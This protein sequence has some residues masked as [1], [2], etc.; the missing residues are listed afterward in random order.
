MNWNLRNRILI[1]TLSLFLLGVAG[2]AAYSSLASEDALDN[3]IRGQLKLVCEALNR[4]VESW[5][6]QVRREVEMTGHRENVVAILRFPGDETVRARSNRLL[7]EAARLY[8]FEAFGIADTKGRIVASTDFMD[9]TAYHVGERGYFVQS[10]RG[11]NSIS[12]IIHSKVSQNLIVVFAS[13]V[14]ISGEIV[15]VIFATVNL[16]N[17]S[18]RFVTPIQVGE[19]GYAVLA[20]ANGRILAHPDKSLILADFSSSEFGRA[21]MQQK[22]GEYSYRFRERFVHSHLQTAASTGWF[23]VVRADHEDIFSPLKKLRAATARI[24]IGMAALIGVILWFIVAG[25]TRPIRQASEFADAVSRGDLTGDLSLN[26]KDEIGRLAASMLAMR[27]CIQDAVSELTVL[28]GKIREGRLEHRGDAGRFEGGW[29]GVIDG[30]NG[31][32]D[33]FAGPFAVVSDYVE[34]IAAGELPRRISKVYAGDF[35]RI[36]K[37]LN[38]LIDSSDTVTQL[39][40][41]LAAGDLTV[42]VVERSSNDRLMQALNK[43][44]Q[45]LAE[46]TSSVRKAADQVALGSRHMQAASESMAEGASRQAASSEEASASMEEMASSTSQNAD[47]AA[48]TERIAVKAVEDAGRSLEAANKSVRAMKEIAREIVVVEDI[49][50][51]TNLL[52]LN[53]AIEAARAGA[54][55]KGF[56]V[57]AMEI[58]KLSEKSRQS[59]ERISDLSSSTMEIAEA[60]GG[61]LGDLMPDIGRTADLVQ[62][63]S[64]ASGQQ[65]AGAQ[66]LNRAIQDL[67][68]VIQ[69]N[70]SAAEEMSSTA[71]EL[72]AQAIHLQEAVSFFRTP[73]GKQTPALYGAAPGSPDE[74]SGFENYR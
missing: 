20:D 26:R 11:K 55:G 34:K 63:I 29:K 46:I 71:A 23:V 42:N 30:V 57:V 68:I 62:E 66:Q 47:N 65:S 5:A 36:R 21:M 50:G 18:T 69:R 41:R 31:V 60:A 24:T 56:A 52:A 2:V 12:R 74:S 61:L 8:G 45:K 44:V 15:G 58:R 59:A 43:M 16:E 72:S 64:A 70:S 49:A 53:A 37:N 25:V 32:V 73:D 22:T 39:A 1:P 13:P 38:E 28:T 6:V 48:R 40:Y 67:E 27:Q 4:Q 3:A 17:F 10:I 51:Q 33:A 19:K 14:R 54:D 35:N 9:G 7:K